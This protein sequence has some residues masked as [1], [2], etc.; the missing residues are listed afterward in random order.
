MSIYLIK[1]GENMFKKII[2]A[3]LATLMLLIVLPTKV[4]AE[5]ETETNISSDEIELVEITEE[6]I[7][8]DVLEPYSYNFASLLGSPIGKC[9]AE[10]KYNYQY[11][12]KQQLIDM[13]RNMQNGG[14]LSSTF[15]GFLLGKLN[16]ILGIIGG[17]LGSENQMFINAAEDALYYRNKDN[18]TIRTTLRCEDSYQGQRGWVHRYK[19]TS[20]YIY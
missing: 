14:V 10:Y 2:T 17:L 12:T 6:G 18:Y 15:I 20:I 3:V 8:I 1:R 9:P 5:N 19:I 4:F 11:V 7:F 13:K 16:P